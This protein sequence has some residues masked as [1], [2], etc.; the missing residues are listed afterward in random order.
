MEQLKI[1][2]EEKFDVAVETDE[3][4]E[5]AVILYHEEID[6]ELISIDVKQI[7]PNPVSFQTYIYNEVSEWIVGVATEAETNSP[8]FLVC[9]KDGERIYEEFLFKEKDNEK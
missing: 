9:L 4:G 7:L 6:E 3:V 1:L 8:L 2:M 5:E